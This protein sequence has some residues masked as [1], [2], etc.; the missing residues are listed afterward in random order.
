MPAPAVI[1]VSD[2]SFDQ[3]VLEASR[4]RPVVVDFWAAWC[5]PCRTLGPILEEA[6]TGH[7]GVTL[8]K[9]DCDA[10]PTTAARFGIRGIPAVKGFRDGQVALEF[11]GLQPRAQVERFLARLAP[12]PPPPPPPADEAGLRAAL[13]REPD[14][15][16][17]R[18]A[19]G[20]LLLRAGRL[21]DAEAVLAGAPSDPVCMGLRARIEILRGD[22]PEL[23]TLVSDGRGPEP[24]RRLIAALRG[25]GEPERSQL[26]RAVV[27]SIEAD[28][29]LEPLRAELAS[30]L[31]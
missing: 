28:P 21:E 12:P 26:R 1:D 22:D 17:A 29:T 2:Q 23:A 18:R 25:R 16:A 11:V 24:V 10:N 19:L 8:A 7:G 6:V 30:V 13:E 27:G 5:A 4:H 15:L 31:F 3:D 20:A 9:L 14:D